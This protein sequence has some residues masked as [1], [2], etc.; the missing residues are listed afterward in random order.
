MRFDFSFVFMFHAIVDVYFVC[1]SR[2]KYFFFFFFLCMCAHSFACSFY[3]TSIPSI[4]LNLS[5]YFVGGGGVVLL[6]ITGKCSMIPFCAQYCIRSIHL[7]FSRS[8]QQQQ[9]EC[10]SFQFI[11]FGSLIRVC[12]DVCECVLLLDCIRLFSAPFYSKLVGKK[13]MHVFFLNFD[14][15]N[16][17]IRA[18]DCVNL[19]ICTQ[20][21]CVRTDC[22]CLAFAMRISFY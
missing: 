10:V 4:S 21:A 1:T 13:K 15:M 11:S 18:R 20:I 16:E 2:M 17:W 14:Q 3:S 22:Q 5:V 19:F 7:S 6:P 12:M 8:F 9:R